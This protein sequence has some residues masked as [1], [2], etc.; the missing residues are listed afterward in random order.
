MKSQKALLESARDKQLA[1]IQKGLNTAVEEG[2][3]S[4]REAE[5]QFNT[6]KT[7]IE[8]EAYKDTE[9]TELVAQDRGIQ[10]SAQM[11]GLMAGDNER[12]NT[13]I[14]ENVTTRDQRINTITDRLNAIKNNS[15]I[16]TQNAHAT[17][18]YGLA[19]AQGQIGAQRAQQ[20]FAMQLEDMQA[21]RDQGFTQDNM[22]LQHEF[23]L[24]KM[25][26]QQQY[27]LQTMAK[28]F[29]Y[30][31]SKMSVAQQYQLA[32]MA[33]SF[34]YDMSLQND[35]QD[36]QGDMQKQ[37]QA[38]EEKMFG[39]EQTAKLAE[40]DKALE[41]EMASYDKNTPEGKL[42]LKQLE[43]SKEAMITEHMTGVFAE[44]LGATFTEKYGKGMTAKEMKKWLDNPTNMKNLQSKSKKLPKEE[45]SYLDAFIKGIRKGI[46]PIRIYDAYKKA[47]Q[48][49]L[50]S[51]TGAGNGLGSLS[52]KYESSGN[53]GVIARTRG[54]IGGASYGKYQMTTASGHATSFAKSYGGALAGKKA[55]TSAFDKAWK[56]E[57]AKNPKKFEQAQHA[58]IQQK[59]YK[60]ALNAIQKA[61]G[62]NF[63]KFPK[64]VH[65]MIWSIGVQHGAGGAS[66]VFRNAGIRKNDSP[67][68][69]IRKVYAER[70]KVNKYF[71][72]SSK[73]VK[74]S[75]YNRFKRELQ[76]ALNML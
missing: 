42:R 49:G 23:D 47:W 58:Y 74:N 1:E 9:R 13:M 65:D 46:A 10:N 61:T 75:V 60:P 43:A 22:Q 54:D 25:S 15:A 68:T 64:A 70:M 66:N 55:G 30:D 21:Q 33:K 57:Y 5:E 63:S 56:A 8:K 32:N 35:S 3:I 76:D 11:L 31:L 17:Y 18:G 37:T 12:K 59:H 50:P 28:Q 45:K 36:F 4:V 69:I 34:G 38:F 26:K 51:F 6:Q 52:A 29:G 71:S 67:A 19:S 20:E 39:K 73:A 24:T 14:N 2:K 27:T 72:S 16:D 53:A 62:I 44:T 7:A 48:D 40:Y 41:R